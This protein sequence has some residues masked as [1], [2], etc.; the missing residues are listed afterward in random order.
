MTPGA[1]VPNTLV[2]L[3]ATGDLAGRLLLPAVASLRAAGGIPPDFRVVG[4]GHQSWTADEFA[5]HVRRR[6][7]AH[8]PG[9]PEA[10]REALAAGLDYRQAEVTDPAD[11]AAVLA[12]AGHDPCVV[13]LALPT[14]LM[15]GAVRA[16]ASCGLPAGSRIA[17]EKPFGTDAA[18]AAE[19]DDA[20]TA[21][22]GAQPYRVDH[23]LAMTAVQQLPHAVVPGTGAAVDWRSTGIEQVELLWEETLALE[24]RAAFYDRA[25]ALRDVV[26]NHLVQLLCTVAAEPAVPGVDDAAARRADVLRGVRPLGAAD[27]RATTRR[28]R[29]TAG[30][31]TGPHGADGR[32]VP[33]YADEEGVDPAR[34]TET[35]AELVLELDTPRWQR[36]RF[37]LRAGKALRERRRGVLVRFRPGTGLP[38][39]WLD[40]DAPQDGRT[41]EAEPA[42]YEHVVRDLLG[43]GTAFAVGADEVE[44]AWRVVTPVLRAWT[45]GK[46]P[47]STYVAGSDGPA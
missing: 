10:D 40:V 4:A 21:V 23:A 15:L 18:S 47:M 30:R 27:V 28:A 37:V 42:A 14:Q 44:L 9:V 31:L 38:P 3:G 16:L 32:E 39:A 1:Q 17:V 12:V 33:D 22:D 19:L 35:F 41:V 43:G 34:E 5:G 45:A 2:V 46:V 25:G 7:T 29:Y 11:V 20:L 36:T 13:Y 26:Q 24:G 6:L 8:A